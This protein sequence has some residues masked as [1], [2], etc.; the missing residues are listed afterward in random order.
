VSFF[1]DSVVNIYA[2]QLL[3]ELDK[4]KNATTK[5]KIN[6]EMTRVAKCPFKGPLTCRGYFIILCFG[7]LL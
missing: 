6:E 1:Y 3:G 7:L 4:K 5:V 2:A